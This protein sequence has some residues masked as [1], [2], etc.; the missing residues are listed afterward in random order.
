[1]VCFFHKHMPFFFILARH[2][3]YSLIQTMGPVTLPDHKFDVHD[4]STK[5]WD[6]IFL[7]RET[8][9]FGIFWPFIDV[10]EIAP[11]SLFVVWVIHYCDPLDLNRTAHKMPKST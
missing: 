2:I 5:T 7:L 4:V 1:M 10:L 3:S 9:L 8:I 6:Q 11:A